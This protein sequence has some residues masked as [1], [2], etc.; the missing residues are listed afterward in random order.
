MYCPIENEESRSGCGCTKRCCRLYNLALAVLAALILFAVGLVIGASF[1]TT[2]T[3][4]IALLITAAI[5]L[6]I[7]FLVT[8]I[9]RGCCNNQYRE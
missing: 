8:L 4:I 9:T 2:F 5:I 3:P 7:V 6:F 1:A